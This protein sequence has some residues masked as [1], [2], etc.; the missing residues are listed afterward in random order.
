M[1]KKIEDTMKSKVVRKVFEKKK[2][3]HSPV[4]SK[5]GS[6]QKVTLGGSQIVGDSGQTVELIN[7]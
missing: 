7:N 3:Y 4:L 5:M 6:M 1:I 2:N